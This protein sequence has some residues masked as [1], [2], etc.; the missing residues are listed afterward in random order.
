M[1][2]KA[3]GIQ[4]DSVLDETSHDKKKRVV[5]VGGGIMGS[6]VA[7]SLAQRRPNW[8][9]TLIDQNPEHDMGKTTNASW[10]WI[11]ANNKFPK[12][13]Q[14]FNQLGVHAW[15]HHPQLQNV[16]SWMGSLMRF[17]AFP[18]WVDDG[19]YPLE[20]PL[21]EAR[22]N[23]L[24]PLACFVS[25]EGDK[26]RQDNS[27]STFF[28]PD[29]GCVEPL[30]T[31]QMLRQAA[32]ELGV[33]VVCGQNVTN[34]VYCGDTG[35]VLHVESIPCGSESKASSDW[36]ATPAN[37]V[38]AA[39]GCGLSSSFFGGVPLTERPGCIEYGRLNLRR[40]DVQDN[41]VGTYSL[42]RILVDAE[43]S[44]HV[45]QRRN[46]DVVAGG[47]GKLEFGGVDN[48]GVSERIESGEKATDFLSQLRL[49]RQLAPSLLRRTDFV[50]ACSAV[51]PMPLDGLPVVGFQNPGLYNVVTHSGITLG[52]FLGAL[53]AAEITDSVAFEI[54]DPFRPSRF[55]K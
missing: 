40:K 35:S 54:L 1:G 44:T 33:R 17:S 38:V 26:D 27:G 18:Q 43:R 36:L 55:K 9:I 52:L 10:A 4:R 30:A 25:G 42:R 51:R 41:L 29:E 21:T 45:L 8:D 11:N 3:W 37:L 20:G 46:G 53:V 31:V 16:V 5:V 32:R 2:L 23:D 34:V 39:A 22:I 47:G 28:F 48:S 50:T 7:L 15:K 12:S 6:S 14:N 19:G 13:Y 24:E 49:A